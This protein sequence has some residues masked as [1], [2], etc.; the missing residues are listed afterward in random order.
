MLCVWAC[1][2]PLYDDF[3]DVAEQNDDPIDTWQA[4]HQR[5]SP[6][7]PTHPILS[8][9]A[10]MPSCRVISM[11]LTNIMIITVNLMIK[12]VIM[13]TIKMMLVIVI[14]WNDGEMQFWNFDIFYLLKRCNVINKLKKWAMIAM[15]W[16]QYGN[17][18]NV[19]NVSN[20]PMKGASLVKT[21][22]FTRKAAGGS[23]QVEILPSSSS[24]SFPFFFHLH[25]F[26]T[27]NYRTNSV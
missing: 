16:W 12:M 23:F 22:N 6:K 21:G 15:F 24:S 1:G 25:I 7:D 13:V 11:I 17:V 3:A 19:C 20:D 9:V 8:A 2:P 27:W 26:S 14:E 4:G 10:V 5:A 18:G